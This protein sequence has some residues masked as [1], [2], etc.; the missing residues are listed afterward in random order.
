MILKDRGCYDQKREVRD[1]GKANQKLPT[2]EGHLSVLVLASLN[3]NFDFAVFLLPS[4]LFPPSLT[5]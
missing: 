4:F 5:N 3:T 1:A 2:P